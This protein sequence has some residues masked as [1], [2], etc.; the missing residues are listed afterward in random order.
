[1]ANFTNKDIENIKND[2]ID[3]ISISEIAKKYNTTYGTIANKLK[4][5]GIFKYT[6]KRWSKDDIDFLKNNYSDT[7]W[8]IIL[9]KLSNWEKSEI[10]SKASKLKLKRDIYFWNEKDIETLIQSYKDNIPIKKI[11]ELL[12]YKFTE[13]AIL[14]KAKKLNIHKRDWWTD[15]ENELLT[16]VYH[17]NDMDEIC[18]MFPNRNRKAIISHASSLGLSYKN[19]W[20]DD[21]VNFLKDN[22]IS[23]SDQ[24]IAGYLERTVDSVRGKRFLEGLKKPAVEG[25]YN[26]L[27]EYIRKHNKDW[28]YKSAQRCNFKCIVTNQRFQAIHHLYG[29]NMI[30]KET[31]DNLGYESYPD[32]NKLSESDLQIILNE[33]YSN[34]NKYPLGIC[35]THDIH[36]QFHDIYGYGDNTPEQFKEFLSINYYT[37]QYDIL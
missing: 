32:I 4:K 24:E 11:I 31:L 16:K 35:L 10:I 36:K 1:M 34:Q 5:I 29:M 2:Y 33:F 3:G 21:E 30:I 22:Y 13:N 9:Q 28:K 37:L 20:E 7:E 8:S 19:I 26:Y 6:N 27:S 25:V 17:K 12:N 18:K 23:M 14:T 15:E